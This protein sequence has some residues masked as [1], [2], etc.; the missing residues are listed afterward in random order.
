MI[1]FLNGRRKCGNLTCSDRIYKKVN[2]DEK[3][4]QF[5]LD[6]N[7]LN[8]YLYNY[9]FVGFSKFDINSIT[10]VFDWCK[11]IE[12][13]C[14]WVELFTEYYS[15]YKFKS[16]GDSR[17]NSRH[18]DTITHN[19]NTLVDNNQNRFTNILDKVPELKPVKTQEIQRFKMLDID[20]NRFTLLE[21]E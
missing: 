12:G 13:Y 14:Y 10:L 3:L 8:A 15:E 21:L 6:K 11:T 5:L 1:V 18:Y 9:S 2:I 17:I 20:K 19:D 7:A 4:K 16:V